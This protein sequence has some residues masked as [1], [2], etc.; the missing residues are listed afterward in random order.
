MTVWRRQSYPVNIEQAA[1]GLASYDCPTL[2]EPYVLSA[3]WVEQIPLDIARRGCALRLLTIPRVMTSR[4]TPHAIA[5]YDSERHR[6]AVVEQAL[7]REGFDHPE[8]VD[9]GVLGISSAY[10]SW[11]GVVYHPTATARALTENELFA[12]ELSVQA[13]WSYSD[14][15]PAEVEADRDPV[16][17][18]T[19]G[20]RYLR[21]VKS[22]LMT[23]RPQETSQHRAMR[24][25]IVSTSGLARRLNQALGALKDCERT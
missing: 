3:Y 8:I 10:A 21:G 4:D 6:A 19:C 25:A 14:Y 5:E 1:V 15:V 12:C 2:S 17:S 18:D 23:E 13:A 24:E 22:R 9:F 16:V 11:S 7:L 20:W